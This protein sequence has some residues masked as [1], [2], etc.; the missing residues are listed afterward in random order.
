[1]GALCST[2]T[3][4]IGTPFSGL[5]N[6]RIHAENIVEGWE[7]W[8]EHRSNEETTSYCH[9]RNTL[10]AEKR[11]DRLCYS[12]VMI[13]SSW[14]I[15]KETDTAYFCPWRKYYNMSALALCWNGHYSPPRLVFLG[16]PPKSSHLTPADM[17]SLAAQSLIEST[18][19]GHSLSVNTM[20][21]DN[22]TLSGAKPTKAMTM[23][24][25]LS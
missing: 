6:G 19:T 17:G 10:T 22:K 16:L 21:P 7:Q 3:L 24:V 1:M 23:A 9:V 15:W 4:H 2:V 25:F 13:S 5:W 11:K 20:S 8:K 18:F 14:K 12:V